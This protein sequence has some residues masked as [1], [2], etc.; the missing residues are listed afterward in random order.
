[1]WKLHIVTFIVKSKSMLEAEVLL[2]IASVISTAT[3]NIWP[4]LF[5]KS[6]LSNNV[7]YA[8]HGWVYATVFVIGTIKFYF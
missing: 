4:K 6:R 7:I 1:M 3:E 8:E 5:S 2:S